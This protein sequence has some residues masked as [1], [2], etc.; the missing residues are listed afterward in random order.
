MERGFFQ[1]KRFQLCVSNFESGWIGGRI[2]L[3][4]NLKTGLGLRIGD[5]LY[6]HLI[7]RQGPTT[8][9]LGDIRKQSRLDFVPRAGTGGKMANRDVQPALI[10]QLLQCLFP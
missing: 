4:L 1:P 10:G 3:S 5:Q 2:E 7:A 8:P 6:D 9:I